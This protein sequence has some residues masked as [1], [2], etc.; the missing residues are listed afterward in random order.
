MTSKLTT[1][2]VYSA[3]SP[4][5]TPLTDE[6]TTGT[7]GVQNSTLYNAKDNDSTSRGQIYV[8]ASTGNMSKEDSINSGTIHFDFFLGSS[9]CCIFQMFHTLW[10]KL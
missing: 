9:I 1:V 10:L 3:S 4:M 5:P 2:P 6:T 8:T 7:Y